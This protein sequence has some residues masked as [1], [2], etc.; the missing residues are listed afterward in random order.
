MKRLALAT[1]LPLVALPLVA[2]PLV[3]LPFVA[4]LFASGGAAAM[5]MVG[6]KHDLTVGGTGQDVCMYCH[7]SHSAIGE[8][9]PLW[10]RASNAPGAYT[11][12]SSPTLDMTISAAGPQGV[13]LACLSCHDGTLAVDDFGGKTG[14]SRRI[15]GSAKV[16]VDLSDDHPISL[17][18]DP[19]RDPGNFKAIGTAQAAGLRFYGPSANQVECSTCHDPHDATTASAFLRISNDSSNLC[20]SCHDV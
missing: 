6:S 8:D 10:N 13:S 7:T 14:G 2:L 16:G 15:T 20:M 18:Y 5:E 17:T 19:S 12:Y 1:I 9:L 4:L 11:M 3:A